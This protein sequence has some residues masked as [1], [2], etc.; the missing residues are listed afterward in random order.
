MAEIKGEKATGGM[1]WFSVG[2][3]FFRLEQRRDVLEVPWAPSYAH[4]RSRANAAMLLDL[5]HTLRGE[6]IQEEW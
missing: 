3:R 2:R 5:D 1:A 6:H 4:F